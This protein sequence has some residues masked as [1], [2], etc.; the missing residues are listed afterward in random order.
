MKRKSAGL[1]F[2]CLCCKKGCGFHTS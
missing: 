2:R 1:I